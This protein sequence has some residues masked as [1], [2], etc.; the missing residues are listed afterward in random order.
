MKEN[1]HIEL[2]GQYLAGDLSKPEEQS[3]MDWVEADA[4]NQA[5]FDELVAIW[6]F[7]GANAPEI[8]VDTSVAWDKVSSKLATSATTSTTKTETKTVSINRWAPLLRIAAIALLVLGAAFWWMTKEPIGEPQLMV[9]TFQTNNEERKEI[10]LPDGSTV[11]LNQ[12]SKL[13]YN[14]NFNP[15]LVELSGEAFFDVTKKGGQS[16]EI[17]SGEGKTTVLGTSFNVRAYP[18]ESKI[19]VTVETG[20]VALQHQDATTQKVL[21]VAGESGA[22]NKPEDK[23]NK[24]TEKISNANAWQTRS[25]FFDD[26]ELSKGLAAL[27]R[28][29][30]VEIKTAK[31]EILRCPWSSSGVLKDPKIDDILSAMA[32]GLDLKVE[33]TNSGYLLTGEGCE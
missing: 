24:V 20:K 8:K 33:K 30:D 5:L 7:T 19:E 25:I 13:T 4:D 15:R 26:T 14:K 28:Y 16:F 31:P 9:Q 17:I 23:V 3:L 6:S 1:N 11:W 22:L 29:F 27:E 10:T 12:N 2:I 32:F 18:D 21:L